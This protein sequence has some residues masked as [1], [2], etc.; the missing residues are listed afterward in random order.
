MLHNIIIESTLNYRRVQLISY[1]EYIYYIILYII[2]LLFNF[3]LIIF[4]FESI[5]F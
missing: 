5:G 2:L 1:W 3:K 4:I